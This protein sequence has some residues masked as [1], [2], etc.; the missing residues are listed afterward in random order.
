M[1]ARTALLVTLLLC[2]VAP[3]AH[4]EDHAVPIR[5]YAYQPGSMTVHVGD[6]VTWTNEDQA[7]HDVVTSAGPAA[8][9]S[10]LLAQGQSWT[11]TF[12]VP[13]TYSYYCS[14]HPDMRA[15]I[16]VLPHE[17]PQPAPQPVAEAPQQAAEVPQQP[18]VSSPAVVTTTPPVTTTVTQAAPTPAPS[19]LN[20]ML[21]LAGLVA[22]VTTFCLLLIGSRPDKG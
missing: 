8:F 1:L 14:V 7:A 10:P 15:E 17:T 20:P 13:G 9:Q 11:F 22:A 16:T 3:P 21:L 19:G 5:Q 18:Q 2:F 4:A 12:T 6:A